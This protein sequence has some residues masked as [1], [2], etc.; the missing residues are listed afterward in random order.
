MATKRKRQR[1]ELRSLSI[2][3]T[4]LWVTGEIPTSANFNNFISDPLEDRAGRNGRIDLEDALRIKHGVDADTQPYLD[5]HQDYLGLPQRGSDPSG[6]TARLY[7]HTGRNATRVY[8]SG[9]WADL[10]GEIGIPT[11]VILEISDIAV[12]NGFLACDGSL[13]SRSVEADLFA[14]V[15]TLFDA[16]DGSTTFGLPDLVGI[17]NQFVIIKT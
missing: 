10:S 17:A 7:Y 3:A 16:G 13:V 12:P 14:V 4:R 6:D 15:G 2:G 5:A 1:K 9:R 8:L 11:G